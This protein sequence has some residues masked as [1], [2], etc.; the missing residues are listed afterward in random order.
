MYRW[1]R[2]WRPNGTLAPPPARRGRAAALRLQEPERAEQFVP[3]GAVVTRL[4]QLVKAPAGQV[5]QV[6]GLVEQGAAGAGRHGFEH[7]VA[8]HLDHRVPHQRTALA[9]RPGYSRLQ[10]DDP[11]GRAGRHVPVLAGHLERSGSAAS[12]ARSR[13]AAPGVARSITS[14]SANCL[15]PAEPSASS[16]GSASVY[17]SNLV[18]AAWGAMAS[19]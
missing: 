4:E 17:T 1:A 9:R 16:T 15:P 7:Q 14:A 18:L 19:T 2:Y 8:D 3:G 11:R 6:A 5:E 10:R 13:S 12:S